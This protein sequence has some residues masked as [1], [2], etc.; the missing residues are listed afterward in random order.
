[1][2]RD[3]RITYLLLA[4]LLLAVLPLFFI[5]VTGALLQP[6]PPELYAFGHVGLF[7]VLALLAM[8][9]PALRGHPFPRRAGLTLAGVLLLGGTLELLQPLFGRSASLVDLGQN[10]AGAFAAVALLAPRGAVRRSLAV[11]ALAAL[12]ATLYAPTIDLWDRAQARQQFPVLGDFETRFEHRRWSN[13]S[14]STRVA[15]TGNRSLEV[16]LRAERRY[17]GTMLRRSIGNWHGYSALQFQVY[18]SEGP[19]LYLTVSIRDQA[20][21]HRGGRYT[22]RFNGRY[23]LEPGWNKVRIPV[24]SIRQAPRERE[25]ELD[26][27]AEVVFFTTTLRQ[28]RVIYLDGVRLE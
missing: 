11:T 1:M 5:S 10:L 26:D 20:H 9:T 22:D 16:P 17:P 8:H 3:A 2:L 27:L 15:Y 25:L 19:P 14:P 28:D 6:V 23:R 21:F 24:D 18:L 4:A 7:A 13:G 12:T